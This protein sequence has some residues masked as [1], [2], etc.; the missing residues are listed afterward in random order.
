MKGQLKTNFGNQVPY[1]LTM[2]VSTIL[3]P[4]NTI[5]YCGAGMLSHK[6][7]CFTFDYSADGYV[8]GEGCGA[9]YYEVHVKEELSRLN[10]VKGTNMNQDGRSASLTAPNGPSQT[11][12]TQQ[13]MRES[14]IV[15]DDIQTQELHGTG[16]P[17]GDPIEVGALKAAMMVNTVT[18]V[19]R[20]SP[21]VNTS[22][23]ASI[24]HGEMVAGMSGVMKVTLMLMFQTCTPGC[25]IRTLNP[26][27]DNAGYPV[28][29][30]DAAVDSGSAT[31]YCGVSS[32]G[33]SGCNAR[34]DVW[35]MAT[36]GH[37]KAFPVGLDFTSNRHNLVS[38]RAVKYVG[39]STAT[40][41]TDA[42]KRPRGLDGIFTS[43]KIT[44]KTALMLSGTWNAWSTMDEME[45]VPEVR[46][47]TVMY[48]CGFRI[49]ET[50]TEDF[51]I[52]VDNYTN[53]MIFPAAQ[54]AGQNAVVLGPGTAPQD[55]NWRVDGRADG[56]Q[57]GTVYV[58]SFWFE[59]ATYQKRVS[60]EPVTDKLE[61]PW[62]LHSFTHHLCVKA[63]WTGWFCQ[64]MRYIGNGCYETS[65]R[66]GE[67]GKEAFHFLR[68]R[69][70]SQLI[71]PSQTTG[72][73][74]NVPIR[75]PDWNGKGKH[76]TFAGETGDLVTL[77]L[78]IID[79]RITVSQQREGRAELTWGSAQERRFYVTDYYGQSAQMKPSAENPQV[80]QV[81][82]IIALGEDEGYYFKI[83]VDKDP[84]QAIYP[85]MNGAQ[86]SGLT[87]SVGPDKFGE[88]AFWVI[89]EQPGS[90]VQISYDPSQADPR[91]VV[92]WSVLSARTIEDDAPIGMHREDA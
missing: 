56:V 91:Q 26:N 46:G 14:A 25:H 39:M 81:S 9:M 64:D 24:G 34:A 8:R 50:L 70:E 55:Y 89:P 12:C 66:I 37:R 49:G 38:E 30:N 2:G 5:A 72:R 75:G 77:R 80:Q 15:S 68:D 54:G 51:C 52:Y 35:G 57:A 74:T 90:K 45:K 61:F 40:P 28:L 78:T 59:P 19:T 6:G 63:T 92:T 47:D 82:L 67:D 22:S 16:T 48:Q 71:Y 36:V 73:N 23:K 13:S 60:W 83:L 41:A 62:P 86:L 53:V 3:T 65:C 4:F 10:T 79:G 11:L 32:F 27:I 1:A 58:V 29:F 88:E 18:K 17:L 31:G 87:S 43:G 69:D 44:D 33:F 76:W 20:F 7:R 85:E 84:D 42:K 21:L